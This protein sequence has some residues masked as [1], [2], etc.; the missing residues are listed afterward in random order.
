MMME[1]AKP[2]AE[3][4][5]DAVTSKPAAEENSSAEERVND[6]ERRLNNLGGENTKSSST[7]VPSQAT[8]G[9]GKNNPLLARIIAA[10]DR[11][12]QAEKKEK[13]AKAAAQAQAEQSKREADAERLKREEEER[14]EKAQSALRLAAGHAL[15]S[16]QDEILREVEGKPAVVDQPLQTV[17]PAVPL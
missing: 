9:Q 10:Q 5:T 8:S 14:I 15:E 13:E 7:P 17:Q 6:L 2:A 12:R 16:K 4:E 3:E 1:R 11:A